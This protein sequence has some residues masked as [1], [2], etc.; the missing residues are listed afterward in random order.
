MVKSWRIYLPHLGNIVKSF[1]SVYFKKFLFQAKKFT[2]LYGAFH[3][4][5]LSYEVLE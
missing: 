1:L 3:I 2:T 5:R 4:A